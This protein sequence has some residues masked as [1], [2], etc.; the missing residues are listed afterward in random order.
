[1]KDLSSQGGH[2]IRQWRGKGRLQGRGHAAELGLQRRIHQGIETFGRQAGRL[3]A[4]RW[5]GG[6]KRLGTQG[7][8]Q[9]SDFHGVT[10]RSSIVWRFHGQSQHPPGQRT[11]FSGQR[12]GVGQRPAAFGATAGQLHCQ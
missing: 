6:G 7:G 2:G 9:G 8:G 12:G 5:S 11:A 1:R 10:P 4:C 3:G